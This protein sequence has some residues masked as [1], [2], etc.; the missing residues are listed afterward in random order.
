METFLCQK[1][2]KLFYAA[3]GPNSCQYCGNLYVIW[4][5]WKERTKKEI[6]AI[7]KEAL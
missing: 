2:K 6:E 4:V 3:C 5:T 7:L 1:C